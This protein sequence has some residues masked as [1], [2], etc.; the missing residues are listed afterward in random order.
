MSSHE[1][2]T[3]LAGKLSRWPPST[4]HDLDRLF[5][6]T[7]D[8]N[9]YYTEDPEFEECLADI[10]EVLDACKAS[11]C[12]REPEAPPSARRP[13]SGPSTRPPTTELPRSQSRPTGVRRTFTRVHSR[14]RSAF[15]QTTAARLAI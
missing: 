13:P 10:Q 11:R 14:S 9:C 15:N 12:T 6:F 4:P 3:L 7:G 1:S 2:R 8:A 5:T